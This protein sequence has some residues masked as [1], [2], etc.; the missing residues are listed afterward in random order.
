MPVNGDLSRLRGCWRTDRYSYD[1]APSQEVSTY[2]FDTNGHGTLVHEGGG[3]TCR[4]P[5][6]I[7]MR[8]DG[9][10]YLADRDTRCSDG[11]IWHQDRLLCTGTQG[12]VA[13]CE[14]QANLVGGNRVHWVTTLHRH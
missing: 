4:A 8:P 6:D 1:N 9:A 13:Q 5:A 10:M 7:E 3:T 12:G 11:S 2:C 14:G